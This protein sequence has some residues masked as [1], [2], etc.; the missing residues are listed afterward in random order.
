[1]AKKNP[2]VLWT[3]DQTGDVIGSAGRQRAQK[4]IGITD[5]EGKLIGESA[6]NSFMTSITL[7]ASNELK[8]EFGRPTLADLTP[9]GST[10]RNWSVGTN[11]QSGAIEVQDLSHVSSEQD[12]APTGT[13]YVSSITQD[14]NGQVSYTWQTV[15]RATDEDNG[16]DVGITPLTTDMY[17]SNERTTG[18]MSAVTPDGV[19]AAIDS[20]DATNAVDA[21]KYITA[22]TETN[23]IVSLTT[24]D[25]DTTPTQNS[26]KPVT[27]GGVAST[28]AGMA[29]QD[30]EETD[31][32]VTS[33]SEANGVI[34]VTKKTIAKATHTTD[35]L[36]SKEDKADFDSLMTY[37]NYGSFELGG[38]TYRTIIIGNL[39]WM[40]DNLDYTDTNVVDRV[41]TWYYN[42][43]ETTYGHLGRLY[44]YDAAVAIN[45]ILVDGWRVP[46][47]D[48]FEGLIN[49]VDQKAENLM[50]KTEWG[51]YYYNPCGL[52]LVGFELLP[53][54]YRD[55]YNG[56]R[57]N[58]YTTQTYLR[59]ITQLSGSTSGYALNTFYNRTI[60][61]GAY[62]NSQG[63]SI[64]LCRPV[65][66]DLRI[67]TRHTTTEKVGSSHVPVYVETDGAVMPCTDQGFTVSVTNA[68]N[69]VHIATIDKIQNGILN[70]EFH[71]YN[72]GRSSI[73]QHL[74]TGYCTI[75]DSVSNCCIIFDDLSSYYGIPNN[76]DKMQL[77]VAYDDTRNNPVDLYLYKTCG[78]II[79]VP[80]TNVI[81]AGQTSMKVLK[82]DAMTFCAEVS[83]TAPS[84]THVFTGNAIRNYT[85]VSLL[86]RN[87]NYSSSCN[88]AVTQS[89]VVKW[90]WIKNN[91]GWDSSHSF[92]KICRLPIHLVGP[93]LRVTSDVDTIKFRHAMDT[94]VNAYGEI[95]LHYGL[96]ESMSSVSY[97]KG[98]FQYH[99]TVNLYGNEKKPLNKYFPIKFYIFSNVDLNDPTI[100]ITDSAYVELWAEFDTTGSR[101][102]DGYSG[103]IFYA[104]A[105]NPSTFGRNQ[106]AFQFCSESSHD[107]DEVMEARPNLI[108]IGSATYSTNQQF[109]YILN[110]N[111]QWVLNENG[112]A[113]NNRL[114]DYVAWGATGIYG[115]RFARSKVPSNEA[116]TVSYS[117]IVTIRRVADTLS[118]SNEHKRMQGNT[119]YAYLAIQQRGGSTANKMCMFN[120]LTPYNNIWGLYSYDWDDGGYHYTDWYIANN[121]DS[122]TEQGKTTVG[123]NL[124]M[125]VGA[126]INCP[127]TD[128][129]YFN[130]FDGWEHDESGVHPWDDTASNYQNRRTV[131]VEDSSN[132]ST[133]ADKHALSLVMTCSNAPFFEGHGVGSE[134]YPVYVDQYGEV[135]EVG[136]ILENSFNH[137]IY[138]IGTAKHLV[139][140]ENWLNSAGSWWNNPEL[141]QPLC[142]AMFTADTIAMYKPM[143]H[144]YSSKYIC[145]GCSS[146]Y[147]HSGSSE[148]YTIYRY[149]FYSGTEVTRYHIA[150]RRDTSTGVVTWEQSGS[151]TYPFHEAFNRV[152]TSGTYGN[153]PGT[154]YLL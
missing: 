143:E 151:S 10:Y 84:R 8:A 66:S 93:W 67:V 36:M 99:M 126:G 61:L 103:I 147:S 21:G 68:E 83:S 92:F 52:D 119:I 44:T 14:S 134:S 125:I 146:V 54:G 7:D 120:A 16:F 129:C 135:K 28:V 56:E 37:I 141:I 100:E 15:T 106:S 114:Y 48:D 75:G 60:Y 23:G 136:I 77:I 131:D 138:N 2:A 140:D 34:S 53:A 39:E 76:E 97:V 116:Q 49:Y 148:V 74:A 22:V 17:S 55:D 96:V 71:I 24:A 20:L 105:T 65:T 90:S 50:A 38:K 121:L 59:S 63:Y 5:G 78:N 72:P 122:A 152:D 45:N 33:V 132:N 46:T 130:I 29:Y 123:I 89:D 95:K 82:S 62:D 6:T 35:G 98:T 94:D 57:F 32:Y 104:E 149:E 139:I 107:G 112:G 124:D 87:K 43:D 110:S 64:R 133:D 102:Y 11:S 31:K 51:T 115:W 3:V 150:S 81:L 40:V 12:A 70:V 18:N 79:I 80:V 153:V 73:Y 145:T 1:M 58:G 109:P 137:N 108:E 154:I 128:E 19:W 118:P 142:A 111:K 101:N 86:F 13:Q 69:Y 25:M 127:T 4:N 9:V 113:A 117:A 42:N 88:Q 27:S 91:N 85:S 30:S 41:N 47:K 144:S 26:K